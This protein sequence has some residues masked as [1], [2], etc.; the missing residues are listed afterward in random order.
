MLSPLSIFDLEKL[1][2]VFPRQ[3]AKHIGL[4]VSLKHGQRFPRYTF[5]AQACRRRVVALADAAAAS[6]QTRA[7][8]AKD[9]FVLMAREKVLSE[10][11]IARQSI[12]AGIRRQVAKQIGV[13]AQQ[14]VGDAATFD[15]PGR[16]S[17]FV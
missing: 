6:V 2:S 11:R 12:I 1:V 10:I 7:I 14:F 5:A 13:I 4:G 15:L 16:I 17:G 3:L 8:A 9:E